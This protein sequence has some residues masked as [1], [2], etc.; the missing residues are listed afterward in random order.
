MVEKLIT[1]YF[2]KKTCIIISHKIWNI[3]NLDQIYIFKKGRI[4]D[5]GTHTDL[6]KRN[7]YYK[8]LYNK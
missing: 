4:I 7:N 5:Q 1:Q 8:G 2:R 3:S 6:F